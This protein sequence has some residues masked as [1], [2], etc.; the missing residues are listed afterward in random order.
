M[1]R[2]LWGGAVNLVLNYAL[3][4]I[5]ELQ[6]WDTV[7]GLWHLGVP[8]KAH[9]LETLNG[10]LIKSLHYIALHHLLQAR[11]IDRNRRRVLFRASNPKSVIIGRIRGAGLHL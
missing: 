6:R 10:F 1:R 7:N 3:H 4:L 2:R 9:G 8:S 11:R 5:P